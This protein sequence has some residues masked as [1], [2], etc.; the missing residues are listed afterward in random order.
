MPD[1]PSLRRLRLPRASRLCDSAA[2]DRL[3][4]QGARVSDGLL[5]LWGLRNDLA[6][7]RFGM[8]VSRKHGNA[9][10]RNRIRRRLR[11]AF[12]LARARLP[13]GLDL[14]ASPHVGAN[15]TVQAAIESLLRLGERLARRLETT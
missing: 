10:N 7:T 5:S 15:I 11:E 3:L 14:A 6:H 12:R 2:F 13:V 1:R 9:V 4:K 8:I